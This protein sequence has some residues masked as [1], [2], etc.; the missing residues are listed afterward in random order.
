MEEKEEISIVHVPVLWREILDFVKDSPF[1]G[2]GT[3]VDCTLG[4]GG[5]TEL[6]LKTFPDIRVMAF[7]RDPEIM[8]VAKK[9]PGGI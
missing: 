2:S 8:A 5:H 1:Q 6:M 7:E 4:E 9:A 3:F